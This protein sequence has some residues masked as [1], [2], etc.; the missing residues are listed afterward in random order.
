MGFDQLYLWADPT[1][2]GPIFASVLMVLI[3]ICYYSLISV[4]GYTGLFILGTMTGVKIYVYVMNT[5][6]K[7]NVQDPIQMYSGM[8]MSISEGKIHEVSTC[9]ASKINATITEL[10]RYFLIDNMVESVKFGLSLWLL[11]YVGSWFNAM[12]L[13]ILAWVGLFSVPKI[14]LNNQAAIDPILNTIKVQLDEV[15]SKVGAFIPA[16]KAAATEAKK[17][18]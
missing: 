10:R 15:K 18:E 16:G 9:A 14:Y 8:D 2:T 5:F 12:T 7:K 6:L 3:A 4:L 1:R 17:E 13:L 11:T